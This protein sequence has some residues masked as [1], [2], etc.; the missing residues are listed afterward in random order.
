MKKIQ[1]K[2]H[3][4]LL[5]AHEARILMH[6]QG[7]NIIQVLAT[8]RDKA[9]HGEG[10]TCFAINGDFEQHLGQLINL[11]YEVKKNRSQNKWEVK[12]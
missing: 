7:N 1:A 2:A 5:T 8:I 9:V 10:S 3:T 6:C 12:W 11:G 4:N